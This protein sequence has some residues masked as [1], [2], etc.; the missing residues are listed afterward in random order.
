MALMVDK[1]GKKSKAAL[2]GGMCKK[3]I[4]MKVLHWNQRTA[5][6]LKDFRISHPPLTPPVQKQLNWYDRSYL[7]VLMI[8]L[9]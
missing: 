4:T 6:G 8:S 9:T 1:K 5:P 7:F 2:G 3:K